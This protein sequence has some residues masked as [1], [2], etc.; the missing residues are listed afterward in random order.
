MSI[1]LYV[2]TIDDS[3]IAPWIARMQE[4]VAHLAVHPGFSF[5]TESGFVPFRITPLAQPEG[6][7]LAEC[8]TGFEIYRG[9]TDLSFCLD[10]QQQAEARL[11]EVGEPF[12]FGAWVVPRVIAHRLT[13][14]PVSFELVWG[15]A[16]RF[17]FRVALLSAAILADLTGGVAVEGEE[18][19]W[20]TGP[21]GVAEARSMIEAFEQSMTDLPVHPFEGWQDA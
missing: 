19:L 4:G 13:A 1:G 20:L 6:A 2:P 21:E 10:E 3:M 11:S 18:G 5:V 14:C 16:D 7:A 17:E 12:R 8:L 9:P 15:A